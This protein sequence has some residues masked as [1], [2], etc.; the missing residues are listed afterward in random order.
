M[1]ELELELLE[2]E[3]LELFKLDDEEF[4]LDDELELFELELLSS[5]GAPADCGRNP[6]PIIDHV[7]VVP[8][9]VHVIVCEPAGVFAALGS[10]IPPVP[11]VAT[12]FIR[13]VCDG[14]TLVSSVA[15]PEITQHLS[16]TVVTLTVASVALP[17]LVAVFVA[18]ASIASANP[19][20]SQTP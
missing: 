14:V 17:A 12:A 16:D 20:S 18:T 3:E 19:P 8:S 4:E 9:P 15:R 5:S 13:D 6:C 2:A 7:D 10:D 11:F 1:S